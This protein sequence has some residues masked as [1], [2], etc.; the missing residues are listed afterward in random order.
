MNIDALQN[1]LRDVGSK[2]LSMRAQGPIQGTWHGTQFKTN[3]DLIAEQ[4]I[5]R[6]LLSLTPHLPVMSEE[7][8][9][10]HSMDRL[11]RYWLVDPIDGTASYSEGYSGFVSQIALMEGAQPIFSAVYAPVSD[12][13]YLAERGAGAT[14]NDK[15][16]SVNPLRNRIILTD[17]YPEPRGIAS[18]LFDKLPCDDYLEAGS[19]GLKICKV[20]DG[21]ANLF[22]KDVIVC[23]WDLAPGHL[24]LH[25]AGGV[26]RDIKNRE[27]DYSGGIVNSHGLIAANSGN[28]L[29]KVS[30]LLNQENKDVS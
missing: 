23:D 7:D 25:E 4:I 26:M 3:A 14:A 13:M 21:Q 15:I 17:N 16:L 24:I 6:G 1:I 30:M 9:S 22:V 18:F 28:L 8:D 12:T 11:A 29:G 19:L 27:I 2:L 5:K 10:S 20:A